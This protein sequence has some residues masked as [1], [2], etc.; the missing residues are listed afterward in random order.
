MNPYFRRARIFQ[1][2]CST[3]RDVSC[4]RKMCV[5]NQ[6]IVGTCRRCSPWFR[7]TGIRTY[8]G[9][10][11]VDVPSLHLAYF[12]IADQS[13]G[14]LHVMHKLPSVSAM[15]RGLPPPEPAFGD[16]DCSESG[17]RGTLRTFYFADRRTWNQSARSDS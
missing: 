4:D 9:L 8:S 11:T 6:H 7:L 14:T 17:A 1:C 3:E 10:M 2:G 5:G 13:P 15:T 16:P 12:A